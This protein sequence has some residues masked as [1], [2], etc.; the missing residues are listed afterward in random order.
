VSCSVKETTQWN[1]VGLKEL[2]AGQHFMKRH[3]ATLKSISQKPESMPQSPTLY[4]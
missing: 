1:K 3:V 4:L 2:T